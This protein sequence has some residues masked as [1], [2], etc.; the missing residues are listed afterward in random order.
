MEVDPQ[1]K[2]SA[3]VQ[4]GSTALSGKTSGLAVRGLDLIRQLEAV[5]AP[6][7]YRGD[8]RR[9]G[10]FPVKPPRPP[11]SWKVAW[12]LRCDEHPFGVAVPYGNS[13]F[14][15]ADERLRAFDAETGPE[16]WKFYVGQNSRWHTPAAAYGM[17][18]TADDKK[19][20]A[21][22]CTTGRVR[23]SIEASEHVFISSDTPVR[24]DLGVLHS[25]AIAGTDLYAQKGLSSSLCVCALT[26]KVR[27]E[28]GNLDSRDNRG[29]E[30]AVGDGCVSFVTTPRGLITLDAATGRR[31]KVTR[32]AAL[33][34]CCIESALI[35]RN[36][37]AGLI[38]ADART[39]KTRWSRNCEVPDIYRNIHPATAV[40]SNRIASMT[41][42]G[43]MMCFDLISGQLLWKTSKIFD[44]STSPM[45]VE[46]LIVAADETGYGIHAISVSDGQLKD[47]IVC[48]DMPAAEQEAEFYRRV[49][50]PHIT[51]ARGF[52]ARATALF[53]LRAGSIFTR[54]AN[55]EELCS[56][57]REQWARSKMCERLRSRCDVRENRRLP[58]L[59]F[60]GRKPA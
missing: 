19:L 27:W 50:T 17:A 41:Q 56:G 38:V 20:Y 9:T 45:I 43:E 54:S 47:G 21:L 60:P 34:E 6:A 15:L 39:H 42:R 52:S 30:I 59:E 8:A 13:V 35:F 22:D 44:P 49:V 7:M 18:Y 4:R 29:G 32:K 36:P 53:I 1:A 14:A 12:T 31:V 10:N 48:V 58:L 37:T 55:R 57:K 23:W 25:I 24:E 16:R 5:P 11:R 40:V 28:R 46:D 26:G 2:A 51:I 33:L 3:I